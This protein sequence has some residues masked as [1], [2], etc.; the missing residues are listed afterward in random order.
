MPA[1]SCISAGT[2]A[3]PLP[4]RLAGM[5][6]QFGSL[7]APIFAICLNA[8]GSEQANVQAPFELAPATISV[9]VRSGAGTA[10][11][12]NT[13]IDGVTVRNALPGIFEYLAGS[14]KVAVAVRV[15]D[16]S[17]IG[18]GNAAHP[19]D[20]IRVYVTGMGPV[21][22]WVPTNRP[23]VGGQVMYFTPL[24]TLGGT[25]MGGVRAEYAENMIGIFVITFQIPSNQPTGAAVSL[26]VGVLTDQSAT[27]TSL[28]SRIAIQ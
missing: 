23:G 14:Q 7:L 8:D 1:G 21:Q 28:A 17:Y 3:G 9:T 24:V 11:P 25:P 4:T 16:G 2:E 27:V 18:P 15:S 19:G 22:P 12:V 10:N 20:E 26:T 6:F 13:T 5:E